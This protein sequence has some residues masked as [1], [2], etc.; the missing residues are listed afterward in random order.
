M[1]ITTGVCNSWKQE[2]GVGTHNFTVTTGN[3]VK[4]ALYLETATLSKDTTVYSAT[5]EVT[6]T[7]YT[8]GGDVLVNV[9]PVLSGDT[10]IF[11]WDD[12]TWAAATIS[13]MRGILFYNSTQA[14]RA[15]FVVDFGSNF[16]VVGA[17]LTIQLPAATAGTAILR[18]S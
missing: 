3:V 12:P 7:G 11:D 2:L 16:S 9:T 13:G 17:L 15:I 5:N 4:A 18:I 8:A 14:N 1:S 6:G 10:C